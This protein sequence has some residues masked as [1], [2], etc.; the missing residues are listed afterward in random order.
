MLRPDAEWLLAVRNGVLA[1]DEV[2][3]LA[4]EHKA[5]L[6]A[7]IACSPLPEEPDEQAADRLLIELQ[8]E[9]LFGGVDSAPARKRF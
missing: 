7:T 8:T 5:R 6:A 4:A 2:L 9:Y 1:Y 3:T